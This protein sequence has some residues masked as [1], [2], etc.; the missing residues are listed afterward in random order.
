MENMEARR[1]QQEQG[2]DHARPG[3]GGEGDFAEGQGPCA[4]EVGPAI[5]LERGN[6]SPGVSL[7]DEEPM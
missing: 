4:E 1:G 2:D 5:V 6:V 3:R 7:L